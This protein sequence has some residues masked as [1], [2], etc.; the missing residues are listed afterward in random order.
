MN[1]HR[2]QAVLLLVALFV[3]LAG[4][5]A[6]AQ[7]PPPAPPGPPG[8]PGAPGSPGMPGTPGAP[9]PQGTPGPESPTYF[10]MDQTT[11]LIIGAIVVLLIIVA[12]VA[13][14]RGSGGETIIRND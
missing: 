2:V 9:G 14:S 10:G 3:A 6:L 7:T 5:L 11:A 12:I 4:G 1:G 8:A 13:V